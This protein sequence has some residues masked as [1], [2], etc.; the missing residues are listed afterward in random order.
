M[1]K[2]YLELVHMNVFL[3]KVKRKQ[4]GTSWFG[5]DS[6]YGT[7]VN[8]ILQ[9]RVEGIRKRGR[10]KRNWMDNVYE[11]TLTYVYPILT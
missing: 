9:G 6:R 4:I 8:T 3:Q 11:W 5:H 10:P 2:L 7:L 1:R